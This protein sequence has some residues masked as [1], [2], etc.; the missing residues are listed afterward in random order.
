MEAG[1]HLAVCVGVVD[2]GTHTETWEGKELIRN[3]LMLLFD[4]PTET[5]DIN[6]E[7]KPRCMSL[8]LTKSNRDTSNFHKYLTSWRGR[9]FTEEE[10]K[11]FHLTKL[12]GQPAIVGVTQKTSNGKTYSKISTIGKPIKGAETP[13][14]TRKIYFDMA[15]ENTYSAIE[16]L[17]D[18]IIKEINSSAEAIAAKKVFMKD[19]TATQVAQMGNDESGEDVPF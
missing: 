9:W 5:I 3:Q 18:W 13:K 11:D 17:P 12:L 16:E 1:M 6:G 10:L 19:K 7:Q 15:D 4:F 2:I 8:K 14:A